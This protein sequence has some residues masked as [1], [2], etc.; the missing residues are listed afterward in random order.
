MNGALPRNHFQTLSHSPGSIVEIDHFS[1]CAAR[2]WRNA[3][4][5]SSPMTAM[6]AMIT[7][8]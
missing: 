7:C 2:H 8:D 3:L 4:D 5:R 6:V 1:L